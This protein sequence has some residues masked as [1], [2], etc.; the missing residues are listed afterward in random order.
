MFLTFCTEFPNAFYLCLHN[1]R[2]FFFVCL[3]TVYK[4]EWPGIMWLHM[5][6]HVMP[7]LNPSLNPKLNP[8]LNPVYAHS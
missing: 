1:G 2:F 5:Y 8:K 4:G 6:T 7:L 3:R